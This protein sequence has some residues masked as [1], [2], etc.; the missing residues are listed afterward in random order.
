MSRPRSLLTG[1]ALL[2]VAT[3]CVQPAYDRTV[4]YE[5][6]VSALDSIQSVGLRGDEAPLSW[7]KDQPLTAIV[8]DSLYRTTVTYR[9]GYLKTEVKFTV[10]GT[11][12]FDNADN[13]RVPF[14]MRG[15]TTI[16]RAR[17]NVRP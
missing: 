8:P 11:F 13:R 15:D 1:G 6:D 3:G 17:F 7:Q 4:I 9:T 16:Y 12:E 14:D 5:L 10:N 2:L